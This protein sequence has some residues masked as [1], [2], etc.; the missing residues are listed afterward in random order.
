MNQ[1]LLQQK[2]ITFNSEDGTTDLHIKEKLCL[3]FVKAFWK[4]LVR[5]TLIATEWAAEVVSQ[6]PGS[7]LAKILEHL[8]MVRPTNK[9]VFQSG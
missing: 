7:K 9:L 8:S 6:G 2:Q 4:R 3:H 5:A 1:I